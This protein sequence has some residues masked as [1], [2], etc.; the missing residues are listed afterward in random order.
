MR[1]TYGRIGYV[2]RGTAAMPGAGAP[3]PLGRVGAAAA[4]TVFVVAA[5]AASILVVAGA[6]VVGTAAF[7]YFWWRTRALRQHLREEQSRRV[8]AMH[9]SREADADAD[10]TGRIIEGEVLRRDEPFRPR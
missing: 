5:C 1:V 3:S 10:G 7:G 8:Q 2:G 4:G 9:T 6:V